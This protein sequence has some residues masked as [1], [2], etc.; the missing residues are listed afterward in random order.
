MRRLD[1]EGVVQ[2]AR[3]AGGQRR[4]SRAE[5]G[6]IERVTQLHPETGSS[7]SRWSISAWRPARWGG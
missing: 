7:R 5:I 2:P 6:S 4:Y 1:T 3:S